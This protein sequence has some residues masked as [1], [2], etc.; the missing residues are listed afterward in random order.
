MAPDSRE[1]NKSRS[2]R[3]SAREPAMCGVVHPDVFVKF[4]PPQGAALHA[5]AHFFQKLLRGAGKQR[6]LGRREAD[7]ALVIEFEPDAGSVLI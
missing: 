2:D 7:D 3:F 5:E 4:F 6:I 1:L